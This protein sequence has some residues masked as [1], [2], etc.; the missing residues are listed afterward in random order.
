MTWRFDIFRC[1]SLV[2][3]CHMPKLWK[4]KARV[5]PVE[6]TNCCPPERRFGTLCRGLFS[7]CLCKNVSF[8]SC[9]S[10]KSS[11]SSCCKR[12]EAQRTRSI[13]AKHSLTSVVAPPLSEVTQFSTHN[14]LQIFFFFF[15]L[16]ILLQL[17]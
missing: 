11:C 8:K 13:R 6:S 16:L 17:F 7:R 10:F 12:S 4:Q 14:Y 5:A 2:Q 15:F 9:C 3:K 1:S